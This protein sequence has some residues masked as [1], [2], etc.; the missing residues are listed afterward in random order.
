MPSTLVRVE[1]LPELEL[2]DDIL[3]G[4]DDCT[5]TCASFSMAPT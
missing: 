4:S 2:K 5:R 1:E 3:K